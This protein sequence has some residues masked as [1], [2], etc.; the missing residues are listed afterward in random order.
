MIKKENY[1]RVLLVDN[2]P[3]LKKMIDL[4]LTLVYNA[5]VMNNWALLL[6]PTKRKRIIKSLKPL[7][8]YIILRIQ[9]MIGV[10]AYN[11][12]RMYG[13]PNSFVIHYYKED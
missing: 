4:Y 6:T 1:N 2:Y 10:D 3:F 13:K 8:N 9:R 7:N 5:S 11:L 12:T